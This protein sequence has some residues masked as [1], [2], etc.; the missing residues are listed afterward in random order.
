VLAALRD[1]GVARVVVS[2]W[3]VSLHDVLERTRLRDLV[4]AVVTSAE[5]GV[6]KPDPA[7]FMRALELAG[8]V[9]PGDAVH[10]GDDVAADVEGARAAGIAPVFVARAGEAAPP[11]VRA[12]PTLEGLLAGEESRVP[13]VRSDD[14]AR[15]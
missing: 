7:I 15:T 6:P 2:N 10:A 13:S 12:V 8:G 9:A 5:F 3:D 14:R 4:D 11:G 1:R